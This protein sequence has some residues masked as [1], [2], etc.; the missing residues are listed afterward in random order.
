MR[1]DKEKVTIRLYIGD[2]ERLRRFFPT[3]DYNRAIREIIKHALDRAE[4]KFNQQVVTKHPAP[5]I[6]E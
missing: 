2:K 1:G 6:G 5:K 3:L 4:E